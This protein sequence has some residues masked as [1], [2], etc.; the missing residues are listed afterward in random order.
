[1]A[2][3]IDKANS[4]LRNKRDYI[5]THLLVPTAYE[6]VECMMTE[7]GEENQKKTK[8]WADHIKYEAEYGYK[9]SVSGKTARR[10]K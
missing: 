6:Y 3:V 2:T 10:Y 1:M 4:K 9:M 8:T 5:F 7:V